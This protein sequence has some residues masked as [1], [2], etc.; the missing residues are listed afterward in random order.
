M[1]QRDEA[2]ERVYPLRKI[3]PGSRNSHGKGSREREDGEGGRREEGQATGE[4]QGLG[5]SKTI[6]QDYF[7]TL[8]HAR[9]TFISSVIIIPSGERAGEVM[10]L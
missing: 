5:N 6:K 3:A 2:A 1:W 10:C 8:Y 7:I 4:K 9:G